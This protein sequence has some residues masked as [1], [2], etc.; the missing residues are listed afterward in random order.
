MYASTSSWCE[1]LT[2]ISV[3]FISQTLQK[4]ITESQGD[5]V[6]LLKAGN[7]L[8]EG[9]EG[10]AGCEEIQVTILSLPSLLCKSRYRF[11]GEDIDTINFDKKV[12]FVEG[13]GGGGG[14]V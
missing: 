1:V 5:V 6:L 13:V 3:D 4:E 9:R 8:L 12:S 2:I 7:D 11:L 14:A 10:A